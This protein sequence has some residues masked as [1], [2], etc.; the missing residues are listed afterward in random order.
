MKPTHSPTGFGH[1]NMKMLHIANIII[2]IMDF[3]CFLDSVDARILKSPHCLLRKTATLH[4]CSG[5]P[6]LFR[7]MHV[8]C[9]QSLELIFSGPASQSADL[10]SFLSVMLDRLLA[11]SKHSLLLIPTEN[12][13]LTFT[14]T[15]HT[16]VSNENT[17]GTMKNRGSHRHSLVFKSKMRKCEML[18]CFASLLSVSKKSTSV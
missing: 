3:S 17:S 6:P 18:L 7:Y 2:I 15:K 11:V 12:D 4:R 14:Q 1:F 5:A 8:D 10:L 13:P 9:P 16:F